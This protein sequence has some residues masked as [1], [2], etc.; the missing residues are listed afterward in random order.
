MVIS[1]TIVKKTN[2]VRVAIPGRATVKAVRFHPAARLLATALRARGSS[3]N[4]TWR[5]TRRASSS[6]HH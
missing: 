3:T 2:T 1:V 6:H 4:A 5:G